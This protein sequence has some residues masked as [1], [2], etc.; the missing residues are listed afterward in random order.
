MLDALVIAALAAVQEPAAALA[1]DVW[2]HELGR[3]LAAME[4]SFGAADEARRERA[5]PNVERAVGAFFRGG[6]EEV[7]REVDAARRLLAASEVGD[8]TSGRRAF[9]DAL[10]LV[11]ERRL[12]ALGTERLACDLVLLY[13]DGTAPQGATFDVR[14][15][16]RVGEAFEPLDEGRDIA[17]QPTLPWRADVAIAALGVGDHAVALSA[18]HG[19]VP[20]ARVD[21]GVSV[22][23]DL[24]ARLARLDAAVGTRSKLE[25]T[26][27]AF[28]AHHLHGLLA[29]LAAGAVPEVDLHAH[30]LLTEAETLAFGEPAARAALLGA[31]GDRYLALPLERGTAVGRVFVPEGLA[32]GVDVPIVF[33]LHGAGGSENMFFASYGAGLA[34]ELARE[35]GWILFAPRVGPLG[36]T[37]DGVLAALDELLPIDRGNVFL[38]GHSMGAAGTVD[39]V[40]KAPGLV[41]AYAALGGGGRASAAL[42]GVPAFVAAGA[43]DFGK[44]GADALAARLRSLG[45]AVDARTYPRTEHLLIVQRALPDVF[46]FFDAQRRDAAAQAR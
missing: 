45:A 29:D 42:A 25:R 12:V 6:F 28:T 46:A 34:V 38:V 2:R 5:L 26:A 7:A 33:A 22:V 39:A 20:L 15:A 4:R 1:A 35:R 32:P 21:V 3:R 36:Y 24:D 14:G 11:P 23:A 19:A 31:P 8:D 40:G 41:R 30:A 18:W 13:G 44:G 10:V 17:V 43:S 9:G 16:R 27:A 37:L